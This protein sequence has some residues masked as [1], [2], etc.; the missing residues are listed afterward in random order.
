VNA[1]TE[2]ADRL[3]YA[4]AWSRVGAV[5]IDL[6]LYVVWAA[7]FSAVY[8]SLAPDPPIL[9]PIPLSSVLAL[10]VFWAYYVVTT[11]L[12][13]G[14]LG[15]MATGLRVVTTGFDRP[16]WLTVLFREVVGRVIVAASLGIGYAWIAADPR[17]Q[18][19]HDKV[20]D[21]LVVRRVRLI[22]AIDPWEPPPPRPERVT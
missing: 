15:K 7:V 10:L 14:T 21:T 5:A 11:A 6:L 22:G 18:G 20:A 3:A 9:G 4:G 12:A 1:P 13:G 2:V 8:A 16:D 19:W 17:K